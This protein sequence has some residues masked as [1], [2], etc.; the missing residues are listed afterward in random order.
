M[1]DISSMV[2]A[3]VWLA[4]AWRHACRGHSGTLHIGALA[5]WRIDIDPFGLV[6][7][8]ILALT[9]IPHGMGLVYG[10]GFVRQVLG[11]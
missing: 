6:A 7:S 4:V 11:S 10:M 8:V 9:L 1:P 3:C 2:W 5:L